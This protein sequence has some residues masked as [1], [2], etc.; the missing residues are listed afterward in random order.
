MDEKLL[1]LIEAI[2]NSPNILKKEYTYSAEESQEIN[3]LILEVREDKF[4]TKLSKG[5][6]LEELTNKIFRTH[7]IY[8]VKK[9]LRTT[10]NEIDLFLEL[11][12]FGTLIKNNLEYN[13]E[14][15]FIVECKNY[16]SKVEVTYIGKFASLMRVTHLKNGIF[17]S[18]K[19]V[20]GDSKRWSEAK[21]LIK[22]IALQDNSFIL[23][24]D[25]S[26][27]EDLEGKTLAEILTCKKNS[28]KLDVDIESLIVAHE[29]EVV[30]EQ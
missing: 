24:F 26:D 5:E 30:E 10:S 13:I 2:K 21:G 16:K 8:K 25:L 6:A 12:S 22:K 9:N 7:K 20:T 28:L 18:K 17:I 23:D 29:L 19:G 14:E 15:E 1:S 27:F 3:K 11:D 4:S